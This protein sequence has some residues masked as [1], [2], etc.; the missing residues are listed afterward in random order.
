MS[1]SLKIYLDQTEVIMDI[2]RVYIRKDT[3]AGTPVSGSGEVLVWRGLYDGLAAG[4]PFLASICSASDGLECDDSEYGEIS[5]MAAEPVTTLLFAVKGST[6]P[7]LWQEDRRQLVFPVRY[8]S[9]LAKDKFVA[10]EGVLRIALLDPLSPAGDRK[11][12]MA[13]GNEGV[14]QWALDE[15]EALGSKAPS[16]VWNGL[17]VKLVQ[18]AAAVGY[19]FPFPDFVTIV[20]GQRCA[21]GIKRLAKLAAGPLTPE[22]HREA[23]AIIVELGGLGVPEETLKKY[24][25][26]VMEKEASPTP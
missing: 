7:S 12:S 2:P 25:R 14:R 26:A 13:F 21:E 17:V 5:I 19:D 3:I 22:L 4:E 20:K 16:M 10:G 6:A 8:F 24:I 15:A 9:K 18:L 23:R 1:A 11:V